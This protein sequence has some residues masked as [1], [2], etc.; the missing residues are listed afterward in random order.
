MTTPAGPDRF[1]EPLSRILESGVFRALFR[2]RPSE[3]PA[4]LEK[5]PAFY[6][7]ERGRQG[8]RTNGRIPYQAFVGGLWGMTRAGAA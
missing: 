3:S 4:K 5:R 2:K 8:H 1:C 7:R 6:N